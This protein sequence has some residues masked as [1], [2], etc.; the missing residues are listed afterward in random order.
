[1]LLN[2][3]NTVKNFLAQSKYVKKII[4]NVAEDDEVALYQ[5]LLR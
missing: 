1:M 2:A 4:F 3:V 5:E